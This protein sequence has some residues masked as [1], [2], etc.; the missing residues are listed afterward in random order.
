MLASGG[1][2]E[3]AAASAAAA[4]D[5]LTGGAGGAVLGRTVD[6]YCGA[7]GDAD[8]VLF[9]RTGTLEESEGLI[10]GGTGLGVDTGSGLDVSLTA[11][12]LPLDLYNS[13]KKNLSN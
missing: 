13:Q 4:I 1:G 11:G 9:G 12:L 10:S 7:R 3:A 8:D 5:P 6:W 2:E